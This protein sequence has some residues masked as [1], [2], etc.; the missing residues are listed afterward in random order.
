LYD[1]CGKYKVYIGELIY[2]FIQIL[3]GRAIHDGSIS[4]E[5][6][7]HSGTKVVRNLEGVDRLAL[8]SLN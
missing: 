7:E 8:G 6:S 1:F 5:K 4:V 2:I 3:A